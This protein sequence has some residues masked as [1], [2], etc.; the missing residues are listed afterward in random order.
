METLPLETQERIFVLACTD[1]GPTGNSLSLTSK[2]I[3]AASRSTRFHTVYLIADA[4][5]LEA[6]VA[7][8]EREHEQ[9]SGYYPP[10]IRHLFLTFRRKLCSQVGADQTIRVDPS[11]SFLDAGSRLIRTIAPDLSSLVVYTPAGTLKNVL[12]FP[13]FQCPFPALREATFVNLCDPT[14]LIVNNT[15][16]HPLLPSMTHLHLLVG[17]FELAL[18]K[19]AAHS[20]CVTHLRVTG[21]ADSRQVHPL[22]SSVG[23]RVDSKG[24]FSRA[25][26][27]FPGPPKTFHRSDVLPRTYPNI[28][29]LLMQPRPT[30]NGGG[31]GNHLIDHSRMVFGLQ[32][33][34]DSCRSELGSRPSVKA[35]LLK[36]LPKNAFSK[37]NIS[38]IQREWRNR[39]EGGEGC[40]VDVIPERRQDHVY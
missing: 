32:Q 40:W 39:V 15:D 35:I 31:C 24:C 12:H 21:V 34:E 2:A 7:C 26:Q 10:R 8:Y 36:E 30:T 22:A 28:T 25:F 20:P 27:G 6:F 29:C 14:P 16:R 13:V 9:A 38:Q 19:W 11:S 37:G 4:I 17:A 18:D 23:V 1:G 5:H 3:R 33:I